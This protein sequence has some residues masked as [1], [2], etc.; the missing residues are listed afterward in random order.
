MK[1]LSIKCS[2]ITVLVQY[3]GLVSGLCATLTELQTPRSF[4]FT[5]FIYSIYILEA[6]D[7]NSAEG[8]L[9]NGA[10]KAPHKEAHSCRIKV[11]NK[12]TGLVYSCFIL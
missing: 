3:K 2:I 6:N 1:T 4:S 8:W 5:P 9:T 11:M 10:L 7:M 12:L